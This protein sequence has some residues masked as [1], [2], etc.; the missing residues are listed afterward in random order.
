MFKKAL[1]CTDF[2]DG[3]FH[4][5]HCI[6]SLQK[7]GFEE[8]VFVHSVP[9]WEEGNI[10]R[11]DQEKVQLAL[12]K[13]SHVLV[14]P[15]QGIKV[16]LEIVSGKPSDTIPRLLQVY[17][18]DVVFLGSIIKGMIAGS[19]LGSTSDYLSRHISQPLL[20][21]RPQL[22]T[23]YTREELNLRAENLYR[24]TLIPYNG[25]EVGEYVINR[26]K[27]HANVIHHCILCWVIDES[28]NNSS[29][30]QQKRNYAQE[31]IQ[32]AQQ[33][34]TDSGIITKTMIRLG[35]PIHE[36]LQVATEE[37]ITLIAMGH[38][39]RS[40]VL[41]WT[42]PNFAQDILHQSWFPL[43]FFRVTS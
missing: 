6:S 2:K 38:K 26:L 23:A 17:Q 13:L 5:T 42:M 36:L 34:L 11:V 7:S 37:D 39:S 16:S 35:N 10:P 43:L 18:S 31:K 15:P 30:S 20:I 24:S 27:N 9:F 21:F 19:F 40:N 14:N 8:I 4:L 25:G 41:Q 29:A 3:L 12:G 1:I 32:L 22:L 33:Q 28:E